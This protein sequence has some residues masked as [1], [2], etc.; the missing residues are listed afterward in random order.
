MCSRGADIASGAVKANKMGSLFDKVEAI[1]ILYTMA[2]VSAW[3][4]LQ[5]LQPAVPLAWGQPADCT[6]WHGASRTLQNTV[7][8]VRY[9]SGLLPQQT[10]G[11]SAYHAMKANFKVSMAA[12]ATPAGLACVAV[13][14]QQ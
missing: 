4:V 12:A 9:D 7:C 10:A 1:I 2:A 11:C 6:A 13:P 8:C 3:M 14:W 5:L